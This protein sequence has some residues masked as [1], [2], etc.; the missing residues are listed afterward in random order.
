MMSYLVAEN[1]TDASIVAHLHMNGNLVHA[2]VMRGVIGFF[3][4]V[5]LQVKH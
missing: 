3:A 2:V 4:C 1:I 5:L